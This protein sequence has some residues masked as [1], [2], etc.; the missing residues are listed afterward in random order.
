L[1]SQH[2][3]SS[4]YCYRT[5]IVT[6]RSRPSSSDRISDAFHNVEWI[7]IGGVSMK[8]MSSRIDRRRRSSRKVSSKVVRRVARGHASKD[9]ILDAAERLLGK[10]SFSQLKVPEL[11]AS[12]GL[13]RA[14]FYVYF[15]SRYE[16]IARLVERLAEQSFPALLQWSAG[17]RAH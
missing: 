4:V 5:C 14:A 17:T 12:A 16:L 13:S 15:K 3:D 1:W 11:M 7:G 6:L 2:A 9:R 10:R 8:R